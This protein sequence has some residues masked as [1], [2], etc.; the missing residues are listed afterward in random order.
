MVNLSQEEINLLDIIQKDFP[1]TGRPFRDIGK[2]AG[3]T[4]EKTITLLRKLKSENII[5]EISILI[6]SKKIGYKSSLIALKADESEKKKIVSRIN[7]HYGVSHNYLRDALFNIW[8][9]LTIP[10]SWDFKK[11]VE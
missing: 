5:L 4:E 9:T 3:L 7:A 1:L 2:R 6:D 11:E 10:G 8:F